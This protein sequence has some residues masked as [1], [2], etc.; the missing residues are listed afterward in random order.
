LASLRLPEQAS[1]TWKPARP[2]G[3]WTPSLIPAAALECYVGLTEGGAFTTLQHWGETT[4]GMVTG[5]NRYFALSPRRAAE[6]DLR[7]GDVIALSP[8]GSRHLRGLDLT[9]SAW[10][11]LGQSGAA[12]LLFRPASEPSRSARRYIAAGE[13]M[14][15]PE[16]YKC[17][18]RS[19][20]WRVPLVRRPDLFVT[21]MNAD[22]PRLCANEAGAHHLNSVH[23]LYLSPRHRGVGLHALPLG[24]LNS[25]T[26]LGAETVG[27]AYGGGMLKLEPREADL[28]PVPSPR[29]LADAADA[30]GAIRE[31]VA[32]LLAARRLLEAVELVD[33]AML[34]GL[35]GYGASQVSALRAGHEE[36]RARRVQR[37]SASR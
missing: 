32:T 29:T 35:L 33:K 15:V 1:Y 21:Y 24:A 2:E 9:K 27:R 26:L 16:A 8:P 10:E 3:K 18:N 17:R 34:E 31:S 30:L 4:L 11:D 25:V 12:T 23:G 5:N 14:G 13:T 37:G 7:E 36:L 20:W 6:L 22:T 28:L 19:P